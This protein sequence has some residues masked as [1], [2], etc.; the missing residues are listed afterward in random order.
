LETLI[1]NSLSRYRTTLFFGL[2][3][4]RISTIVITLQ[5]SPMGSMRST[6][7]LPVKA[8]H[9]ILN[10]SDEQLI[11]DFIKKHRKLNLMKG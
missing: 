7:E 11:P 4:G 3:R 9:Y 10:A 1:L 6:G 5:S 2:H 8:T